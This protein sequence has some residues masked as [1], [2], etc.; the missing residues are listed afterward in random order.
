MNNRPIFVTLLVPILIFCSAFPSNAQPGI[1]SF[2]PASGPVGSIV[3]ITGNNL[4][5]PISFTIGGTTC[6]IIA[7]DGNSLKGMVMPGATSGKITIATAAG[8]VSSGSNFTI[9]TTPAPSVQQG[10][11]LVGNG[12]I[13]PAHQGSAVSLSADGNTALVGAIGDN[14][15]TGGAWIFVRSSGSWQQQGVKLTASDA[16][17]VAHLG[18]SVSLSA[19]GNTALI[20]GYLDN[21]GVNGAAWIF[22]RTNNLWTQQG[23]KLTVNDAQGFPSIGYSVA[24]SADG[25]TALVG[26][27]GDNNGTGAAWVFARNGTS[28]TQ[29]GPKLVGSQ[30]VSASNQGIAVALS[31]DGNTALVGGEFDGGGWGA[32]WVFTRTGVTWT[33]QGQKLVGNDA[34]GAANQGLSVALSADGN[35]ALV[36]GPLDNSQAGAAWV[37]T[38][39]GAV[40]AQ[41]GA[42]LI[43]NNPTGTSSGMGWSVALTADGNTAIA[44]GFFDDT[45]IGAAWIFNRAGSQ[46]TQQPAKL[47]GTGGVGMS[48]QGY[49]VSLSADGTTALL[50]GRN[51]DGGAGAAWVFVNASA[52]PLRLINFVGEHKGNFN[53]LTWTT[54]DAVSFDRFEIQRSTDGVSFSRVG[55][56]TSTASNAAEKAYTYAD[57]IVPGK[58]AVY[59]YRLKMID[60]SGSFTYSPVLK[61]ESGVKTFNVE[62]SPNPLHDLLMVHINIPLQESVTISLMDG[63]GRKIFSKQFNLQKGSNILQI[64]ALRNVQ[65]GFY[66]I[67]AQ[68]G[69]Y[70]QVNKVIKQ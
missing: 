49:S 7:N 68:T 69:T 29:Q 38:R 57:N 15:F 32:A 27:W 46:W 52:L 51:D 61:L 41:Q 62:I 33:Q 19:D 21:D 4:N 17:G 56:I 37:Y 65:P 59:Y 31:A 40:W 5:E 53:N 18:V 20:G 39:T 48:G 43:A 42:K 24:L 30:S 55:S 45:S 6:I 26:G 13:G 60:Q 25:N 50:G 36:G 54:A 12:A 22:T 34:A 23:T 58:Y 67:F 1:Q 64:S 16:V 47:V 2:T 63:Q 28:W 44:G 70:Q 8:T 14:S 66:Y 35:T 11:K 3:T 9:T 10:V